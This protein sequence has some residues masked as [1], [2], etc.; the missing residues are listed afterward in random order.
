MHQC[1]HHHH[2]AHNYGP[3][4]AIGVGLNV[5]FVL[6][7]ASFG[8]WTDSLALL[9]DAG[10]NLSDVLGLLLAWGGYALAKVAPSGRRTYGWRSSTILAALMNAL[11]LLVAIGGITWEA[12]HRLRDPT[13]V[14]APTIVLV[15]LIGVLINAATAMLFM[16][17]RHGDLNIRGAYLHMAADALLSL[18]VAVA[19]G[20]I[21]WT[22]WNW[23][24]PMT[25]LVIAGVIFFATLGL[26]R[27]SIN[28][29]LQAV[30]SRIDLD[31]VSDYLSG[32]P[33]VRGV[34]DLHVWAMSTTEVALTAH[35]V[36]PNADNE[37]EMLRQIAEALHQDF[38]IGHV[39]I[40]F[41]RSVDQTQ[42]RQAESGSL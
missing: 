22:H 33:N 11:L 41:E 38:N 32:L 3:A 13:D 31:R 15:A 21:I 9:A 26:L 5:A 40:Q 29:L 37:D 4:F 24:D 2:D 7:E 39:T 42:C 6:I 36:K 1:A 18:G 20:I 35:L 16:R 25:S 34:H 27:E 30:P 17:G 28:L 23:I 19:G 14:V 8:F 12:V 10:H